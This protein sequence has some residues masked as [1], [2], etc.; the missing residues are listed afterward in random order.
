MDE[1]SERL[2][3]AVSFLKR[4]GCA[5]SNR[6][7][8]N[9]LGITESTVCMVLKGTRPP[10]WD[11]ILALCDAYPIEFTWVRT[12]A[13]KMIKEERELALLKRIEELE[14]EVERLKGR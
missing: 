11:L 6:D 7:I 12:G 5:K 2:R 1:I 13:G 8:A 3:E 14:R 9:R 4:N 10:T